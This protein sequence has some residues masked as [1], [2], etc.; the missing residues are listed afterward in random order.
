MDPASASEYRRPPTFDAPRRGASLPCLPQHKAAGGAGGGARNR[1]RRR[2]HLRRPPLMGSQP[3]HGGDEGRRR[4]AGGYSDGGTMA[5]ERRRVTVVGLAWLTIGA[6]A[7]L[8]PSLALLADPRRP[9]FLEG[10]PPSSRADK[11][12]LPPMPYF[13]FGPKFI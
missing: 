12:R 13:Q 7:L 8:R 2:A 5:G 3:G 9:S 11:C 10:T 6:G 1:E 4:G